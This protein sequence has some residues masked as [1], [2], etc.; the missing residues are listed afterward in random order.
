MCSLGVSLRDSAV[1][2]MLWPRLPGNRSFMPTYKV[3]DTE[4]MVMTRDDATS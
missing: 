2:S 3:G 4:C 1:D